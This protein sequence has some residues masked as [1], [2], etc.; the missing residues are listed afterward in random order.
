MTR[1]TVAV[2]DLIPGDI[3][4]SKGWEVNG[5]PHGGPTLPGTVVPFDFKGINIGFYYPD[6]ETQVHILR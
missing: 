3:V 1:E 2:A 5:Y 6:S 4:I